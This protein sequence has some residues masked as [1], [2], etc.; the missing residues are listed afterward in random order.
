MTNSHCIKKCFN[1]AAR[2]YDQHGNI[3]K[4]VGERLLTLLHPYFKEIN[5]IIDLGCGTGFTTEKLANLYPFYQHFYA[6]DIAD[7]L[8][9][10]ATERLT[11]LTITIEEKNF[12]D[13]H[14]PHCAF[15]LVFSNMA[16]HW[17]G[18][19]KHT[20]LHIQ[21]Q[22][23][24]NGLFCFSLPL[25]NTLQ[26]FNSVKKDFFSLEE[27]K[28]YLLS[29]KFSLLTYH[30][31][32]ILLTFSSIKEAL[33]SLKLTGTYYTRHRVTSLR[34]KSYLKELLQSVKINSPFLLTYEIGYF[35][36]RKL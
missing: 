10:K 8:L 3:Q 4:K 26:E 31:E 6:V 14:Y 1:K 19:I 29:T 5:T 36:V 28:N 16:L 32:T 11:H 22:M 18:D 23:N 35:L 34:G 33:L 30:K 7:Q 24:K 21:N 17:S 13:F 25:E 27:I 2:T 12:N 15:D 20:F 9:K